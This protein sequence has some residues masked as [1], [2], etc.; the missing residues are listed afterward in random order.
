MIVRRKRQE[1]KRIGRLRLGGILLGTA[2][3]ERLRAWYVAAF[4]PVETPSGSPDFGGFEMLV[5]GRG[6]ASLA[7]RQGDRQ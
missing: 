7:A 4:A 3:A 6:E 1:E 2:D 5:D